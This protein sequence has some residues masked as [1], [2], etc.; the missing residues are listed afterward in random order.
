MQL[1]SEGVSVKA[2]LKKLDAAFARAAATGSNKVMMRLDSQ[3]ATI[4][5]LIIM[6]SAGLFQIVCG[7]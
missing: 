2:A 7:R 4:L 6:R 3:M 1:L 5:Q